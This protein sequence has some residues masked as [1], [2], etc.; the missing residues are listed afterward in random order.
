MTESTTA[1]ETSEIKLF[2]SGRR[3]GVPR[4]EPDFRPHSGL[5]VAIGRSRAELGKRAVVM[6]TI[7]SVVGSPDVALALPDSLLPALPAQAPTLADASG[8]AASAFINVLFR[9]GTD[10]A[11]P[12]AV[13]APGATETPRAEEDG[14]EHDA[15]LPSW[16][17]GAAPQSLIPLGMT[18]G[19]AAAAAASSGS[20]VP[21][22]TV[23][24]GAGA[25]ICPVAQATAAPVAQTRGDAQRREPVDAFVPTAAPAPTL[26]AGARPATLGN[27]A[28]AQVRIAAPM[29]AEGD[30]ARR[31]S[32][33]ERQAAA[34]V[35]GAVT[36]PNAPALPV[37][38][39]APVR[40]DGVVQLLAKLPPQ[41]RQPLQEALGERLQL[42]LNRGSEHAVI[43]L[44]PPSL[45]RIEILIRH[46]GGVLQVQ[47][48][49]SN[50]EVLRQ[51][52]QIGDSLRHDLMHRQ[53]SDVSVMV[54]D[55]SRDAE[56]RQRH[57][58]HEA[59]DE[60]PN[61]ALTEAD[62][63]LPATAFALAHDRD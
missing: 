29:L 4:G 7:G 31:A 25:E 16:W 12:E 18:W 2:V 62:D 53:Y 6:S 49:A 5:F 54:A 9:V 37:P 61:R 36:S 38:A 60:G 27:E 26:A 3:V 52:A 22:D 24:A 8:I 40:D 10:A 42:Q 51:L 46:E 35:P 58:Q 39:S 30:P 23:Q 33:P 21:A 11:T 57:A 47:L 48:S 41:W 44:D 1:N 43:R 63:G 32:A 50:G 13:P 45:G 59:Q 19:V 34:P 56:G 14:D 15:S 20:A 28:D 55:S 17:V